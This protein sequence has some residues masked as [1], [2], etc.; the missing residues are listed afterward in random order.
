MASVTRVN[1]LGHAH[2]TLYSTAQLKAFVIDAG[3]SLAAQGGIGGAL[4]ALAQEVAPLMMQSVS[5]SGVVHV[6]VDGHAVDAAGL[7]DR[8]QNLGTVNGYSFSGATVT[9]GSNIVVS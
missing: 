6:I 7:E 8:I 5:T 3:G 4:E 9:L 2:G 1:G